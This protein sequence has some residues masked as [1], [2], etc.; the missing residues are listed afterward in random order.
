[1]ELEKLYIQF[2]ISV[3]KIPI[4]VH[5]E[6]LATAFYIYKRIYMLSTEQLL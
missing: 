5:P 1:M 3:A 6:G 4:Q 2:I